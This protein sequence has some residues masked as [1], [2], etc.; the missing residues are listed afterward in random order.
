MSELK[1]IK[2]KS[3]G[4]TLMFGEIRCGIISKVCPKCGTRNLIIAK[5]GVSKDFIVPSK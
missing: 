3:C 1:P 2:C 5:D 4:K